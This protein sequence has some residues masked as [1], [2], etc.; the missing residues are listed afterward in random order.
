MTL[1]EMLRSSP[2]RSMSIHLFAVSFSWYPLAVW[3][4]AIIRHRLTSETHSPLIINP[5]VNLFRNGFAFNN[6]Q[7]IYYILS[8]RAPNSAHNENQHMP[9]LAAPWLPVRADWQ[10]AALCAPQQ[11]GLSGPPRA[12]ARGAPGDRRAG[13]RCGRHH[14]RAHPTSREQCPAGGGAG[15]GVKDAEAAP[16]ARQCRHL[17]GKLWQPSHCG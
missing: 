7:F 3:K 5:E 17:V 8:H 6:M 15:G 4:V 14:P 9:P 2:A 13:P 16:S 12:G 1:H 10:A 11:P